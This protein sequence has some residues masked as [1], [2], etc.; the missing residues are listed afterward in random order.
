MAHWNSSACRDFLAAQR[1]DTAFARPSQYAS[2]FFFT[3]SRVLLTGRLERA[4][5]HVVREVE[6]LLLGG[7][8]R[9]EHNRL[10]PALS[11]DGRLLARVAAV[12]EELRD[13]VV[14]SPQGAKAHVGADAVLVVVLHLA[15]H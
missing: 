11:V 3:Q 2:F 8:R 1:V 6:S 15:A 7:V 4:R 10:H 9:A 13:R 12:I 14:G 5:N